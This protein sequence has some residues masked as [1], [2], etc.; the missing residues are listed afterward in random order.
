MLKDW[1]ITWAVFMLAMHGCGAIPQPSTDPLPS[2]ATSKSAGSVLGESEDF[3]VVMAG[4]GD[5]LETLAAKYL[6]DAARSWMIEDFNDTSDVSAGKQIVIPKGYWN[7]TGVYH[8]GY[9]LVPILV[10]HNIGPQAK[11][12]LIIAAKTFQ[13]QMRYL[14]TNGFRAVSLGEYHEFLAQKRQLPRKTVV[15]TFDDGYKS[16][17]QYAYP[18]FKELGFSA[19][20]F[21]YTDYIGS[22]N[23]L[24][25]AELK[26]LAEEGF[27]IEAHTKTHSDLKRANG[28]SASDYRARLRAELE[29]P[30]TLF[31]RNLGQVPKSLAYPYGAHDEEV[32]QRT[33]EAGY[34]AA[35]TVRRQ[36]TYAFVDPFRIHRSQIYADMSLEDFAKNLN[37][38]HQEILK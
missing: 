18:V 33:K 2:T 27:Q 30:K 16:F 7:P 6:G 3:F 20:V 36:G 37:V 22:R 5:T 35:F 29:Q 32:V 21:V 23:A 26:K 28:E 1:K 11:G 4:P 17:L 25:W 8:S 15:I 38:F 12:R 14:K 34:V 19:T 31:Q 13:E 9:Q 24:S 10:Y